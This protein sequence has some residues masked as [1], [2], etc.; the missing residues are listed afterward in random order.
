M[1]AVGDDARARRASSPDAVVVAAGSWSRLLL[2]GIGVHLPLLSGK[3]YSVTASGSGTRPARPLYM[4][5]SRVALSP[6]EPDVLRIGGTLEVTTYDLSLTR[7]RL[8]LLLQVTRKYL[9]EWRPGAVELEWAGLR[10]LVS[11]SLPVVGPI[12]GYRDLYVATGHGMVGMTAGPPS[13]LELAN[14]ILDGLESE[15][16]RP[17]LSGPTS[18]VGPAR[19]VRCSI[20]DPRRTRCPVSTLLPRT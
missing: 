13:G 4:V 8:D 11:D 10:P 16:I 9:A 14:L 1:P 15:I 7:R 12:P 18:P 20:T 3:G 6:Y 2:A 17:F 19:P 5:D